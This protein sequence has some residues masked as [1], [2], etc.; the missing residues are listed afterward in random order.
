MSP[1]AARLATALTAAALLFAAALLALQLIG[2]LRQLQRMQG[3]LAEINGV[4]YGLLNAEVWVE[5]IS[6]ILERRI[7]GFEVTE[8]NRPQLKQNIE[9]VLDRLLV[10]VEGYL[11]RRNAGGDNWLQRVRGSLQQGVQDL[12]LDFDE[13]RAQVPTYAN[14]VLDELN[15]PAT[16]DDI[17][18]QVLAMVRNAADATFTRLDTS[19]FERALAAHDCHSAPECTDLLRGRLAVEQPRAVR[20]ALTLLA[21]VTALFALTLA[22]R[23]LP[24]ETM[25][26]LTVA[27]LILLA[28]GV[29]TPMIEVEA[30]ISELRFAL[31]GSPVRFSDQVLYFQSKS[32]IDV[33]RILAETGKA[34]MLLVAVLITLF[35]VLFPALKVIASFL[36]YYDF[37][38]LRGN[39]WVCFFALRSGKW[40]MAD[41]LVVAMFM[42]YIGFSGLVS[43]QLSGIARSS[44][45]V[46]VITTDGT[47]LQIGFFM[48]LAFVLASLVLS[49]RLESA[50]GRQTS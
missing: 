16:R 14:A 38:G 44:R 9:V 21:L 31:L 34:D 7:D 8:T 49:S 26:M 11:H 36:Y 22:R 25:S 4:Q 47:A 37:H 35:S 45:A 20:T 10:E 13:L 30:R 18:R 43:S 23:R 24:P 48:F 33:V 46:E 40:S 50:L 15:R 19:R 2:D 5:Q 27:T 39:A 42:A 1:T 17:K 6:T 12:V 28:T 32:I 3:D 41:V 29:L